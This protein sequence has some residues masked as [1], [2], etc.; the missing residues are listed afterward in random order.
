MDTTRSPPFLQAVSAASD[1]HRNLLGFV[2][3]GAFEE[4]ARRNDL[5][6]LTLRRADSNTEYVGHLLFGRTY[7]R[8]KVLQLL[9]LP[10]YRGKNYGRLL[11]NRLVELLTHDGFTSIYAPVGE[12]MREANEAWQAMGFRVQRT[13]PGGITTGR[14]IVVRVRE[15]A[16][17]QLFPSHAVDHA[18]P[19]GLA[20]NLSIETPLFLID[21]NVLFDL[22]PHRGRH[23]EALTLFH[24]ERASFCKLAISDEI[25]TELSRTGP[26][27]RPDPMM[28][29][30]RTFTR[31]P[32]SSVNVSSPIV[33]KLAKLVFPSKAAASLSQNDVSDLRHLVT[34]IEN[35]LAGLV[36]ND[37][38]SLRAAPEIE[39]I[40]GVQVLSP[41]AFLPEE[42][43]G[44]SVT[45]Y[46]TGHLD[47]ELLP[48]TES[49]DADTRSLL[50]KLGV[51]PADLASGWSS[52]IAT[53]YV[54]RSGSR[55]VAYMSWPALRHDGVITIRAAVDETYPGAME[56]ARGVIM[57]CM[58]S[59]IDGP[60]TL[61]LKTAPNQVFL[62][63]IA[64]GVGF[65]NG[66]G[67]NDLTKLAFGR[68]ATRGNWNRR[69]S[70]LAEISELKMD[71]QF[72]RYRRIEQQIP[73]IT[74]NG[75]Y[76]YETLERIETLL[77]PAL[78]CFPERPAV[79][80][81]ILHKYAKL[82]LGHSRQGSLLP[83]PTSN[84]F[85]DRHFISG[86][87]AFNQLKRGTLMLF[88]ESNPPRGK[89][90]LVA[91]ARVRRS[92]LKEIAAFADN[93][94]KQ[95]V[96]SQETLTDIGRAKMKTVTVFDNMFALPAPISLERLQQLDCGSPI[97]L[98]TTR[99]ISDTQ[100]QEIL[101]EAFKE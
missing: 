6:V 69:R 52:R 45:A 20:R 94:L 42:L 5:L 55:L 33:L 61:R 68:V 83:A 101:A 75:D 23:E 77:S 57:Q 62:R 66:Q 37:Q 14:T 99:A 96:L 49:D 48:A 51:T 2:P 19:L 17:P 87:Q 3:R 11:C 63:D 25:I 84:L 16:S 15:L 56:A 100:L 72:P 89:G 82:L 47:L 43:V 74:Q 90:E 53:S 39:S 71:G 50:A 8:A 9:V 80:T 91:I 70:E 97:D 32:V 4:L 98:I 36:T 13:E 21:L 73:Y 95:S 92:Y 65:C 46:E 44:G 81:P 64:K 76:G 10:G 35:N 38:A 88:Y 34:A 12:D 31:F 93:D 40:F 67:T 79:I 30:A 22:S 41:K 59:N 78:F 60:T 7:P 28:N 26:A 85:Q 27:G 18:D 24:A 54:V 1:A 29:I 58:N 86:P